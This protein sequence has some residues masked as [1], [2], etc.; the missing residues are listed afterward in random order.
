MPAVTVPCSAAAA[1]ALPYQTR[2][3][4]I[5]MAAALV[6]LER[7]PQARALIREALT[8]DPA[9]STDYVISQELYEDAQV[10][11]LLLGRA[12]QAG[13]PRGAE[14]FAAPLA[15]VNAG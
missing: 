11:A 2:R 4:R 7:M 3:S 9:L 15:V 14:P 1:S 8:G 13:L 5:Y 10:M 12:V 6:A